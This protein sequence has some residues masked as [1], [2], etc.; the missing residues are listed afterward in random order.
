MITFDT[1]ESVM[2]ADILNYM[3]VALIDG[4]YEPS[5]PLDTLAKAVRANPM[6][7]SALYVKGNMASSAVVLSSVMKKRDFR[8]FMADFL[9]FGNGYLQV[10]RNG[11]RE[12]VAIKHLPALYMRRKEKVDEYCYKPKV[13]SSEGEVHYRPGQVFHLTEYDVCQELYGLPQYIGALSSI[14]L[15]EDATLF[16]RKYYRNGSHAGYLLYMNDASLTDDQDKEIRLKLSTQDAFKNLFVNGKGKDGKKP[17]LTPIGQVEA[18][19]AFK[20]IKDTTTSD[21][22][23]SHRIPL[24]LMSIVREG[25]TT[26]SD[27]NKVDRIFYKNELVPLLELVMEL[28]EFVGLEVVIIKEYEGLEP[29][30]KVE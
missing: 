10:V 23:A 30:T 1:P 24:D 16:R 20:A 15:N 3:E 6:H 25:F 5:I 17:E 26:S 11:L 28:N 13:F 19:D 7:G 12:I 8:R 4:V 14:W 27:L 22:L 18:K 2:S 29:P 9:T 21:V